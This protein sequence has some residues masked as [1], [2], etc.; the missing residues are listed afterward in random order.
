MS[1]PEGTP[2]S[3]RWARLRFAIVG[4]LL[5]SPPEHGQ[6]Q[7]RFAELAARSWKHP[8]TGEMTR[9]DFKTIER[10][11]YIARATDDP[12][13]ALSRKV[14]KHAGTHPSVSLLIGAQL[15]KQYAEH[16]RWTYQLHHDELRAV[17]RERPELGPL[18]GYATMRRWMK[19]QG[20]YRAKKKRDR[21]LEHAADVTARETRS[22]EVE[23]VH[24]LWHLDFHGCSRA[25]LLP[26]GEWKK[27]ELLGIIDDHSRL[28]C[29][30][31]WY[32]D[33][34]AESLAHG[35]MQAILKRGL[36]RRILM[37]QGSA[38][39][40][41]EIVEGLVRLGITQELTL[42]YSPEQNGKQ[43]NFWTRI[44]GRLMAMLEGEQPL[45][46]ALLNRATIAWLEQ[47]YHRELHSEI[48]TTPLARLMESKS[49]GRP[50]PSMQV[51]E[52][53]FR[54]QVR[55]TQ[56]RSDGTITV[57]GV[58]FEVPSVYRTLT[59]L[60]VRVARWDL[61]SVDLV[62][63]RSETHLATLLPLDKRK[64][65]DGRR[66]VLEPVASAPSA[67]P[68]GMATHLRQLMAEH[69]ATGLPPGYLP[70]HELAEASAEE[71]EGETR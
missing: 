11:Y 9:F 37:D 18:P 68:T 54:M 51:L 2:P 62:D 17:A 49:V 57:E 40:A 38:M 47:E 31:Q 14:H 71:D 15:R 42:E 66:R 21:R 55:R 10:W 69:A 24:A 28:G 7:E 64:N 16:P 46:L 50:S 20:L 22:Y 25:V 70:K 52:R 35:L 48:G 29:H 65:A 44:E 26:S 6:L 30:V 1:D 45:T 56:R 63:P 43:E 58:R 36:P 34:T 27:P 41:A 23:Y 53:A 60:V 61:S 59:R 8:S 33:E 5:A 12:V 39:R 67:T 13:A 32:L 19:A 4:P 3:V